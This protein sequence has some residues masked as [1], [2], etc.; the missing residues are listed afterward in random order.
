MNSKIKII[1][2]HTVMQNKLL[3]E[4]NDCM[5]ELKL[6]KFRIGV[7]SNN[8]N[9]AISKI[10]VADGFK[11]SEQ[12]KIFQ[13]ISHYIH[14]SM[15]V[16]EA[17]VGMESELFH[18]IRLQRGKEK[19]TRKDKWILWFQQLARWALGILVAIFL[20]SSLVYITDDH[21]VNEKQESR[22]CVKIPI[23]DWI[24]K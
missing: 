20:Y 3:A 4:I 17:L 8:L 15:V 16:N 10:A 13:K 7:T 24:P 6:D 23:K 14:S 12:S 5:E 19:A 11:E 22:F 9:Q 1:S 21:C 18:E 2:E